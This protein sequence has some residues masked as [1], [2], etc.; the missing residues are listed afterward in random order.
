VY[1]G[2]AC[3]ATHTPTQRLLPLGSSGEPVEE[4]Q[5]T[6]ESRHNSVSLTVLN[7]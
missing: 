5:R 7:F 1:E 3:K 6:N 4:E 2:G